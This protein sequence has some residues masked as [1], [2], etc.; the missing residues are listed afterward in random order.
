MIDRKDIG[1]RNIIIETFCLFWISSIFLMDEAE[2]G[3]SLFGFF[4]SS[5]TTSIFMEPFLVVSWL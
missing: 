5:T 1:T 2:P 3:R 4:A